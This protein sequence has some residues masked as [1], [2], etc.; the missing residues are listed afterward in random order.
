[1]KIPKGHFYI[2]YNTKTMQVVEAGKGA[3]ASYA[4]ADKDPDLACFNHTHPSN[5]DLVRELNLNIEKP[6]FRALKAFNICIIEGR[7]WFQKT[8]GN[9]YHSVTVTVDGA[10]IGRVDFAYGYGDQ[11]VQSAYDI[12]RE[13]GFFPQS[14]EHWDIEQYK[15]DNRKKFHITC[16]DVG[17]RKDL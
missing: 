8:Y 15:R 5:A 16:T 11:Y 14:A 4:K 1:M 13:K 7:R 9:T 3:M 17:R 2:I 10:Q 12:L 6:K